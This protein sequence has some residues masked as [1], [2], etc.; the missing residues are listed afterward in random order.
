MNDDLCAENECFLSETYIFIG[1]QA[2]WEELI[3]VEKPIGGEKY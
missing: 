3:S 1:C 2:Q